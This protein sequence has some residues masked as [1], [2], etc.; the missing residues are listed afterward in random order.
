MS[1]TVYPAFCMKS[2]WTTVKGREPENNTVD[3]LTKGDGDWG[4]EGLDGWGFGHNIWE[5]MNLHRGGINLRN[6]D[7]IPSKFVSK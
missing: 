4:L 2:F 5:R 1:P 6:L 3:S 7:R